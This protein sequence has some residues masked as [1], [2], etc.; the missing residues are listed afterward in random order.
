[1]SYDVIDPRSNPSKHK[2]IWSTYRFFCRQGR[3]IAH[4]IIDRN[5]NGKGHSSIHKLSVDLL[6]VKFGSLC[7]HD[8]VSKLAKVQN[9]G[10]RNALSH[11]TFQCQVDNFG[12]L[13][14]LGTYITAREEKK[15]RL[16]LLLALLDRFDIKGHNFLT[17]ECIPVGKISDFF[18]FLLFTCFDFVDFDLFFFVTH[19]DGFYLL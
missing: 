8:G 12:C 5:A 14:I 19:D 16:A 18:P 6:C 2:I 1:M 11:Q 15:V 3:V 4:D 17:Q 13:L 10:S 9:V 7:F